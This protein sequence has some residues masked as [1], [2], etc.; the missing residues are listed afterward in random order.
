MARTQGMTDRR[1][2]RQVFERLQQTLAVVELDGA[3]I[4]VTDSCIEPNYR[5]GDDGVW[6]RPNDAVDSLNW[7]PACD[8]ADGPDAPDPLTE[9]ALPFPFSAA[10]L[11][12][13]MLDGWGEHLRESFAGEKGQPDLVTQGRRL[14][15]V[16]DAK[17]REALVAAF[18]ALARAC[19][20]VGEPDE[21]LVEAVQ[22]AD[23]AFGAATAEAERLHDWREAGITESERSARVR[24]RNQATA[25]AEAVLKGAREARVRDHEAWRKAMVRVL[26][27]APT[28]K[29]T[30]EEWAAMSTGEQVAAWWA[31]REPELTPGEASQNFVGWCDATIRANYWFGLKGINPTEAAQLLSRENPHDAEGGHWLTTSSERMSPSARRELLRGFEDVGGNQPLAEWLALAKSRGWRHDP[32]VDEYIAAVGGALPRPLEAP[33]V[34]SPQERQV[35]LLRLVDEERRKSPRKFLEAAAEREGISK[36]ALKMVI[37]RR[38]KPRTPMGELVDGLSRPILPKG[39]TKR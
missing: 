1:Y 35:R 36:Y 14:G 15:G 37:Y 29:H 10:Q 16:R 8:L 28:R 4:A 23:A 18:S 33:R 11:A 17:P 34:E 31:G 27:G 12:A 7:T 32:W 20:Q 25:A 26:L 39:R 24:R 19:R 38:N 2:G 21:S 3:L 30:R 6:L 9:P 5:L 13:F 22:A